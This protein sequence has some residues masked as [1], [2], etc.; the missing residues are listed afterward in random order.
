MLGRLKF[1]LTELANEMLDNIPEEYFS[2][3]TTTFF[4]PAMA[5]GQFVK[6][7][8]D[9]LRKYGHTDENITNRVHGYESNLMRLNIAKAKTGDVG[10]FV[11]N[12]FVEDDIMFDFNNA[13]VV[14]NPPYNDGTSGRAPIYQKFLEKLVKGNPNNVVFIIPTNWFSQPHTKLGK[15]VRE[16]LKA[17]GVYK[18]QMNPVDLFDGVTVSTC[19]VFCKKGYNSDVYL[20][21]EDNSK[22]IL[23]DDL[24]DQILIEF[25]PI[26]LELLNKLKPKTAYKTYAGNKHDT[27]KWRIT[28]SYR[29]ERFDLEPLNPL[30]VMEP[31]Y[32]SQGGY[33]V[34]ASFSSKDEADKSLEKYQSFWHS[35]LVKFIM[36]RTRTSTTLDNPQLLWV[37][38]LDLFDRVYTDEELFDF[39]DLTSEEIKVVENDHETHN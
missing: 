27:D 16:Y 31:D 30:K 10:Q 13:T 6:A 26:S 3:S 25:N 17:L 22:S 8:V 23:I 21:N 32:K 4:D 1:D 28:T 39:F 12:N 11:K 35:K 24:N 38:K 36:R 9:R 7:V 34:F 37:P 15:D 29:K 20:F 33:R 18:I 5:G 2:S 14:G 19:T